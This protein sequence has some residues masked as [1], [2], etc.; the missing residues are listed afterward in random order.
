MGTN[1]RSALVA[2]VVVLA[3]TAPDI[4]AAGIAP[5]MPVV[6]GNS[7]AVAGVERAAS[8]LKDRPKP[9]CRGAHC[10]PGYKWS[11]YR[12]WKRKQYFGRIVAGVALGAI[13]ATAANAV[14]R[15]PSNDLCWYWTNSSKTRGYWDYCS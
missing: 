5:P 4:E 2:A 13:I 7:F 6:A 3:M 1:I 12:K 14:P 15:R 8:S 9:G 11:Q 10:S